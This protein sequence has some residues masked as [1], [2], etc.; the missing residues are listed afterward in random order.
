MMHTAD[1]RQRYEQ[2]GFSLVE[3]MVAVTIGLIVL[4]ALSGLFLSSNRASVEMRKS[5]QQQESGR[6]ASQLLSDDLM[7]AGYLAEF[8]SS[9]LTTPADPLPNACD[10]KRAD[11]LTALPLHVQGVNDAATAIIPLCLS[12]VKAGTDIVVVRRASTCAAGVDGCA[13]FA[14]GMPYFQASLCMPTDG[15][16]AELAHAINNDADYAA[17]HFTLSDTA[18][19]FTKRKTNCTDVASRE[20]YLVHIYFI[21]NNNEAG[22][23]IPTLKLAELEKGAGLEDGTFSIKPMVDGIE[24]MQI[25]YGVDTTNDGI[26][27]IYTSAPA[28]NVDWRNVMSARIHL[29]ARNTVA[30]QGFIDKRSY[31]LGDKVV[32]ASN[33]GYKRHVYSTTVQFVNPS[34]RRQ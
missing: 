7:M 1:L 13:A 2:A 31:T 16:G 9:P 8:D 22:D 15:S 5:T 30:T 33:D 27:D 21:A 10:T 23:G 12:D 6:Y 24:N 19:D 4:M 34:W 29:L 14:A 17:H 20:R 26:P 32:A 18:D 25:E 3:L 28:A 11:L